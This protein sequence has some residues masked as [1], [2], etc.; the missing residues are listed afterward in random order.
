[1]AVTRSI[2]IGGKKITVETGRLA[3]QANGAVLISLD[4]NFVLC[5]ATAA[6]QPNPGQDFFPLTVDYREKTASVG[7]IP[8]GFFKREGRP[9]EK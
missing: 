8:G 7:K 9:T 4:D 1:M 3:R 5:T 6:D 2:D